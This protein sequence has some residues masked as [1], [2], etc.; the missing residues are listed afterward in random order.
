MV[1]LRELVK[2]LSEIVAHA[3]AFTYI[4]STVAVGIVEHI[5]VVS[6]SVSKGFSEKVKV[7]NLSKRKYFFKK[8]HGK[9]IKRIM[10]IGESVYHYEDKKECQ[11]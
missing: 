5:F 8:K 7:N 6:D 10:E 3:S 4:V 11:H 2:D 9:K 1:V